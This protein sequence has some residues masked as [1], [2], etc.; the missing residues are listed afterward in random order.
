MLDVKKEINNF[1]SM[2]VN[3]FIFLPYF[4]SVKN[5]IKTLFNP[6]KNLVATP[7]KE[8]IGFSFEKWLNRL[9]FNLIS[10]SIGFFARASLIIFYLFINVLVIISL[11]LFIFIF[12]IFYLPFKIIIFPFE[13]KDYEKK[14]KLKKKFLKTHL[15]DKKNK[16]LVESWFENFYQKNF[17]KKK[18]WDLENLFSYPPLARD[19]NTGYTPNLDQYA[20]NLCDPHYLNFRLSI[21]NRIKEIGQIEQILSKSNF[22]NLIIVGEE[23]VGKHTIID[24]LAKKIYE[25]KIN[26]VL[27]YKRLLKLNME[28]ILSK[29]TDQKKRENFFEE[30]LQE[31]AQAKNIILLIDNIDRYLSFYEGRIDMTTIIEKFAK[32]DL[33]Q[34]IG[35]TEPF[36]YQ[37]FIY[38]NEKISRLFEKVD[39]YEVS[40][41]EAEKIILEN[42]NFLENRHQ[43][44]FPYET[45]KNAINKANFYITEIPFPEKAIDLLDAAAVFQRRKLNLSEKQWTIVLPEAVDEVLQEKTHIPTSITPSISKKLLNLEKILSSQIIQQEEAM[46][47]IAQTLRRS[48]LLLGK[49]KKPLASFLFLGPTGVGKTETAKV[50]AKF[51]FGS[52][53]NLL[54]FDMSLYQNKEDIA[55]LIGS[56]ENGNPGLLSKAIR[57]KPYGVL[58][59]DEIEKAN[60][61]LINI[62]LTLLDEGYFTDGFGKR[63]DGKNLVIIATSNAGA[64]FIY[65]DKNIKDYTNLIEIIIEKDFFSP[66]FINRFDGIIFFKPLKYESIFELGKRLI[67]IIKNDIYQLYQVKVVINENFL[68]KI[69]EENYNEKFGARNLERILRE[70]IE[71]QIAKI[72]LAKKPKKEDII[73]INS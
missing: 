48:F 6:W 64:N 69:I 57:E 49:R 68:K 28:K 14:E 13:E 63:V 38:P 4:F 34:F 29:F 3:I 37:K 30:L 47:Q 7:Q 20:I 26:P 73:E 52:E 18:W 43:V 61:D 9:F 44:F 31:A 32:T 67:E 23:G 19:W 22:A 59:L 11:P 42:F 55:N 46:N 35:I 2:I 71:D 15:L 56:M 24:A 8:E 66:E 16:L 12:F 36:F 60:R 58:L 50:L 41:E 54:R 10:R 65:S 27:S 33:I 1:F 17:N 70:K 40:I 62:F 5:L 21:V 39:V 72:I 25:G 53:N 51:F 45:I